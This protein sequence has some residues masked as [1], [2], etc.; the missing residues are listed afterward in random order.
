[1]AK[2]S[3]IEASQVVRLQT[4]ADRAQSDILHEVDNELWQRLARR[5]DVQAN[6]RR[7]IRRPL[8]DETLFAHGKA[9][10]TR[11]FAER[12]C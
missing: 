8:A 11:H 10:A 7:P 6:Q 2:T 3:G 12:E 4:I 1:M 5:R 9:V